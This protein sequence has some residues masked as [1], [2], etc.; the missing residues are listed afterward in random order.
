M[1]FLKIITILCLAKSIFGHWVV[2]EYQIQNQT[3]LKDPEKYLIENTGD[4]ARYLG[5]LCFI[6]VVHAH[7]K[8][9]AKNRL[10]CSAGLRKTRAGDFWQ[11]LS[12]AC[13]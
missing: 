2:F 9:P 4:S 12:N 7:L 5:S 8:V 13:K 11:E 6:A 3:T 10:L 1:A